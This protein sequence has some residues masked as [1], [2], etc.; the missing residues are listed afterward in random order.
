MTIPVKVSEISVLTAAFDPEVTVDP[1]DLTS[2]DGA[3]YFE[4]PADLVVYYTAPGGTAVLW[5]YGAD[6]TIAGDGMLGAGTITPVAETEALGV[7]HV[8]R[9]TEL[10][11]PA[12]Y[13]EGDG[14]P[15]ATHEHVEDKNRL[16]D[17][18]LQREITRTLR[19]P[20]YEDVL[21]ILPGKAVRAGKYLRGKADGT[22]EFVVLS[23]IN[24]LNDSDTI[25]FTFDPDTDSFTAVVKPD[26]VDAALLHASQTDIVFGRASAGAGAGRSCWRKPAGL[27]AIGSE[28]HRYHGRLAAPD[29][30]GDLG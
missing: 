5:D 29:Q 2:G 16:I 22:F 30:I 9:D 6:Y 27:T 1:I 14:F 11:Q 17:Q 18:D 8:S 23:T 28:L 25:D 12:D 24:A 20:R 21:T 7:L 3:L 13:E 15:A 26:S 4:N 10:L 19:I